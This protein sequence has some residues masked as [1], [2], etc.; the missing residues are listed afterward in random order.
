MNIMKQVRSSQ[1]VIIV[2]NWIKHSFSLWV[3]LSV[4]DKCHECIIWLKL[5]KWLFKTLMNV[6]I[7]GV[8]NSP[9]NSSH[10][11]HNECNITGTLRDHTEYLRYQFVI[12][13]PWKLPCSWIAFYQNSF[14]VSA[15]L[16]C[17]LIRRDYGRLANK[18]FTSNPF[19]SLKQ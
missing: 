2:L 16:L 1:P 17:H 11:K 13:S 10:T 8:H 6:Y 12:F 14:V 15:G 3:S 19:V 5:G 18:A 4:L 7:P 9:K